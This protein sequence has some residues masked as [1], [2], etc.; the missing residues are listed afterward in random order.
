MGSKIVTLPACIGVAFLIL[1]AARLSVAT[2]QD[3][4]AA[5]KPK[6]GQ[7]APAFTAES[8]GGKKI[9]LADYRDKSA[10]LLVFGARA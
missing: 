9:A 4:P 8:I 7:A 3:K 6:V 2:G 5:P 1:G 10:V